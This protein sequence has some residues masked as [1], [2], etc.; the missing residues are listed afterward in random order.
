M[1]EL[2]RMIR[3]SVN[4]DHI[5]TLRQARGGKEPDPVAAAMLCEQ[6]GADGITLHL[7]VDRRHVQ[8]RDLRLLRQM[9]KTRLNLE[10]AATEEMLETAIE[11]KPDL[12]T[13]VPERPGEVTTEGGLDVTGQKEDL[14]GKIEHLRTAGLTVSIF[15]DPEEGQVEA[16]KAVGANAIELHTGPYADAVAEEDVEREFGRLLRAATLAGELGLEL[17]AG[18]SLTFRNL[19]RI[20]TLP[21]LVEVSIGHNV[22]ARAVFI[23]LERAVK[24]L[25]AVLH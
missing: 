14:K 8:D 2:T 3:L 24:E 11:A 7:R 23:G 22:V 18:H 4:I 9:V 15:L 25:L 6:A 5:A 17:R 12:C 16:A 19:P 10:M 20:A 21:H 13:L 1:D